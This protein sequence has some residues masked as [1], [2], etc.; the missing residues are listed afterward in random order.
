[1]KKEQLHLYVFPRMNDV[2]HSFF[3]SR[4]EQIHGSKTP[5]IIFINT[6]NNPLGIYRQIVTARIRFGWRAIIIAHYGEIWP[7]IYANWKSADYILS[8]HPDQGKNFQRVHLLAKFSARQPFSEKERRNSSSYRR[9]KEKFCNFV[10]SNDWLPHTRVRRNFCRQLM[11]YKHVDCAGESLNNMP[12]VPRGKQGT[13]RKKDFLASYKFTIAFENGSADF[14]HTEKILHPFLV[15]SIPIYWGCP[16]IAA[17]YNPAAFINCHDYTSF[18]QVID[19]VKEIDRNPELYEKYRRAPIL[20]PDFSLDK[21]S[22]M[23]VDLLA[24]ITTEAIRRRTMPQDGWGSLRR[25]VD[26]TAAGLEPAKRR[27]AYWIRTF[28]LSSVLKES[29]LRIAARLFR[30]RINI[31]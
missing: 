23:L 27:F 4:Y 8:F 1:M 26:L 31:K 11:K 7:D 28:Y 6:R 19:R 2:P 22:A 29:A 14:Y 5:D 21:R 16:Q 25:T 12:R 20:P 13:L 24:K 3:P 30:L 15:G 9:P 17:H 10:Y 18:A